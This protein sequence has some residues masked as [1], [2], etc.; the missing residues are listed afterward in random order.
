[1]SNDENGWEVFDRVADVVVV[2]SGASGFAAAIAAASRGASVLVLE[3]AGYVGG[4]T[5]KSGGVFWVPN[6]PLMSER[7]LEDHREDAIK[8]MCRLAYPQLYSESDST[9]GL[10]TDRFEAIC[11]FYDNGA[12]AVQ[13]L[14]DEKA[15]DPE[16]FPHH[17]YHADLPED[18]ATYGRSLAPKGAFDNTDGK[19]GGDLLI[20]GMQR[21]AEQHGARVLLGHRV[22]D[23]LRN[24]DNE[25]VGIE[26]HVRS[27]AVFIGAK[28]GVIF[29]SGGFVH[30]KDLAREF[31]R[32]PTFGGCADDGSVGDFVR[33]GMSLPAKFGN[34]A[35]AWWDQVIVEWAVALPS[36]I[37][38]VFLPFGDSMI[39]VNRYGRRVVNEKMVYN[40][41]AQIHHHYDPTKREFANLILFQ[42]YDHAVASNP[43]PW[44][45]RLP[46]PMPD[47]SVNYVISGQ[48]L[49][50]LATNVSTR[51]RE[52][53]G[54]LRDFALDDDFL[55]NLRDS[56]AR[57]NRY[58]RTGVDLDFHRGETPIQVAWHGPARENDML[59]PTMYPIAD[60]GPYYCVMLGPGCLDTKGGPVTDTQ[61]QVVAVDDSRITGLF[62]AG[63]CVASPAG[64][65]Y[66]SAGGTLGPAL[67]QG[68]VAGQSAV[69][70]AVHA[71]P[72]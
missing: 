23:V 71:A 41:R 27:T 2:G 32:G 42:I 58:A 46:V 65:A 14:I 50:E 61:G 69:Q 17:D 6:N 22:T 49:D 53:A 12:A 40:E 37:R 25:V 60:E 38:D 52:L 31:L 35:N 29:A 45:W 21:A 67:V 8:Y 33:I 16:I 47:E 66:W 51:L 57:F 44:Q 55:E 5:I 18:R 43:N 13:A 26:A 36:T 34:M 24:A 62:G 63:N 4:T 7:G 19:T 68:Y 28:K 10:P 39:Q 30:D 64:Q 15:I 1:M 9:L 20:E 11:S 59:N 48:T 3:Q 70:Q 56:I 72:S 54:P